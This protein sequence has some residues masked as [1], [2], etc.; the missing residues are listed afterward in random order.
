MM[1]LGHVFV[2]HAADG[3]FPSDHLTLLW[4]VSLSFLLHQR[5]RWAGVLLALL[6]LPVAWAR[7]YLGVH[8]PLDMAGAAGVAA[9][10][11]YL[12]FRQERWYV[13]RVYR[14]V[15]AVYQQLLARPIRRGWLRP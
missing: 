4:G 5:V 6:G 8:F 3:S 11:A 9:S 1:G 10:S 13:Q 2:A 14:W 12:C 15:H 7:I